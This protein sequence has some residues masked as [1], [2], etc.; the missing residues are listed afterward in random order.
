MVIIN[1]IDIIIIVTSQIQTL[2]GHTALMLFA[3]GRLRPKVLATLEERRKT[4]QS[5]VSQTSN[6]QLTLA[7]M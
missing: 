2:S 7:T 1:V 5:S 6:D 4:I 3:L